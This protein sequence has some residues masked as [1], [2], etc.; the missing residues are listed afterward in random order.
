MNSISTPQHIENLFDKLLNLQWEAFENRVPMTDVDWYF[1]Y[2]ESKSNLKMLWNYAESERKESEAEFRRT[3]D[4]RIYVDIQ[5]AQRIKDWAGIALGDVFGLKEY[6]PDHDYYNNNPR[7]MNPGKGTS[8]LGALIL[9]G[10]I[11]HSMKK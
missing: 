4:D 2:A 1:L 5:D 10:I 6:Y 11:G 9:G 3:G 8:V 7:K